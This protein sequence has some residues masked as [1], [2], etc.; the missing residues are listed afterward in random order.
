MYALHGEDCQA[1]HDAYRKSKQAHEKLVS[2]LNADAAQCSRLHTQYDQSRKDRQAAEIL[3][4]D[5]QQRTQQYQELM[6][7][8]ELCKSEQDAWAAEKKA[9]EEAVSEYKNLVASISS[10]N[11]KKRS[12]YQKR[13]ENHQKALKDWETQR[14]L[15]Q[16]W[17]SY[18]SG[19]GYSLAMRWRSTR[20]RYP[21]LNNYDGY[22]ITYACGSS[23]LCLPESRKRYYSRL[24]QTVKGLGG[25]QE[26]TKCQWAY[27]PACPNF[28]SCPPKVE[29]PGAAPK[30]PEPPQYE[31]A[32]SAENFFQTK[33]VSAPGPAPTCT[34][35]PRP[36]K[37]TCNPNASLPPVPPK[38]TCTPPQI[39]PAP[40]KPTCKPSK[41]LFA[42]TGAMWLWVAAGAG[43]LYYLARKK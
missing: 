33:G 20:K 8:R 40:L 12:A 5:C 31:T 7:E 29:D 3:L 4:K 1:Q 23:F 28:S 41:S 42:G 14:K 2:Q 19:V 6:R 17:L 22:P 37:P 43:G 10:R 27:L 36:P 16:D 26:S 15:Y 21:F 25:K 18:R 13:L 24:C 38:P 11:A 35:G 34:V 9:Y 32:P 30:K 39:P